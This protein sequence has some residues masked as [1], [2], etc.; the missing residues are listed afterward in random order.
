MTTASGIGLAP[1]PGVRTP[2]V[3]KT[4]RRVVE[5]VAVSEKGFLGREERR[6]PRRG[7]HD[8]EQGEFMP[9]AKQ[10]CG[11]SPAGWRRALVKTLRRA[12]RGPCGHRQRPKGSIRRRV[13]ARLLWLEGSC[14]R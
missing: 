4:P 2:A 9:F 12:C 1:H 6:V 11:R 13:F 5:A 10:V 3:L 14:G 7:R 8:T